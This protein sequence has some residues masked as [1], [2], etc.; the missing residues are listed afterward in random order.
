MKKIL[1]L[2]FCVGCAVGFAQESPPTSAW[3]DDFPKNVQRLDF[4]GATEVFFTSVP[5]YV[6]EGRGGLQAMV[7]GDVVVH[8]ALEGDEAQAALARLR[9]VPVTAWRKS[10]VGVNQCQKVINPKTLWEVQDAKGNR[11]QFVH[12]AEAMQPD[13]DREIAVC[14]FDGSNTY[15][16]ITGAQ[17]LWQVA[18]PLLPSKNQ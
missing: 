18:L 13:G 17:A 11:H 16:L 12:Q 6:G 2:F 1:S 9:A 3:H 8:V 7:D 5:Y 15:T 14:W 4:Y 10:A